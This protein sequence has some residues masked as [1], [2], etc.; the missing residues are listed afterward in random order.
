MLR[1]LLL[2][3]VPL[4]AL[5]LAPAVFADDRSPLEAI[6]NDAD[7][8]LRLRQPQQT[9]DKL[10]EMAATVRRSLGD[11]MRTYGDGLGLYIFN[12]TMA[13]VDRT[14]DWHVAAFVDADE[15]PA[16]VFIIPATDTGVLQAALPDGM[17]SFVR[18]DWVIYCED[19]ATLDRAQ[20]DLPEED[21]GVLSA[22][23]DESR[24]V[25]DECDVAVFVNMEQV[26]D[27]Y[28]AGLETRQIQLEDQIKRRLGLL[29]LIPGFDP[30]ALVGDG[31]DAIGQSV[32]DCTRFTAG[33]VVSDDGLDI[34]AY[35]EFADASVTAERVAGMPRAAMAS[36]TQL[37][38]DSLL[39]FGVAGGL[40]RQAD[41]GLSTVSSVVEPDEEGR[42]KLEELEDSLERVEYESM[43]SALGVGDADT[44]YVRFV[45]IANASPAADVRNVKQQLCELFQGED[46]QQGLTQSAAYELEAEAFG[47]ARADLLTVTQDIDPNINPFFAQIMKE[48]Q[49]KLHGPDGLQVRL[50]FEEDRYLQ[51]SGGGAAAMEQAV[52]QFS[53]GSGNGLDGSLAGLINEPTILVLLDVQRVVRLAIEEAAK[54]P[55]L[56]LPIDPSM[57]GGANPEASY[58]GVTLASE[59]TALRSRT[60]VPPVQLIRMM[61]VGLLLQM[62]QQQ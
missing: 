13:G 31:S 14:R 53:A 41:W 51:A 25:F 62:L 8:V 26:L 4:L 9:I 32:E 18:D 42:R 11:Q 52:A 43:V 59:S 22:M 1:R 34:E 44:G 29:A 16:V 23:S 30:D 58:V 5:S 21:G 61:Q 54:N 38:P 19:E 3:S 56:A 49:Q 33:V 12:P 57:F 2:L 10:A 36:L 35:A 7:V 50:L 39:Y 17:P 6:S 27:V 55:V 60:R 24:K 28:S 47:D 37:P 15:D 40:A 46:P 48:F 20:Q 45:S